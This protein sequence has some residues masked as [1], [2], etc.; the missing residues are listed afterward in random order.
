MILDIVSGAAIIAGA[1]FV[2]MG[3]VGFFRFPDFFTRIHAAS[4]TDTAGAGLVLLGLAVHSGFSMAT[5]KLVFILL[6]SFFT[7]PTGTYAVANSAVRFGLK[8]WT[9]TTEEDRDG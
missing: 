6:F 1:V 3:V 5:L 9:R 4:V 2:L 8:P 7:A